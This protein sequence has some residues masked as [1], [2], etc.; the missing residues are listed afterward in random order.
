MTQEKLKSWLSL[1]LLLGILLAVIFVIIGAGIY[2]LQQGH[3]PASYQTLSKGSN[4]FTSISSVLQGS[5]RFDPFALI[6]LGFLILVFSQ[7]LRVFIL[8]FS[9]L[10][11]SEYVL[12]LSSFFIFIVLIYS[13]LWHE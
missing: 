5:F 13:M 12:A 11:T 2:L 8:G 10:H 9:F 3:N 7:V 6:L 4:T 1:L